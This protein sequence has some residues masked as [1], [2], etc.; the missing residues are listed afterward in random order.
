MISLLVKDIFEKMIRIQLL[1][2]NSLTAP[3]EVARFNLEPA[4]EDLK[5]I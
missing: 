3:R 2:A 4:K 1:L 5:Q